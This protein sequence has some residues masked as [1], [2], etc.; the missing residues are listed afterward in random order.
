MLE[1]QATSTVRSLSETCI[2]LVQDKNGTDDKD[3]SIPNA[4]DFENVR[5]LEERIAVLNFM[6]PREEL[7]ASPEQRFL[8]QV[9]SRCSTGNL[10]NLINTPDSLYTG[11]LQ[12]NTP[13]NE[14]LTL[15]TSS[16]EEVRESSA[17]SIESFVPE[18]TVSTLKE[19]LSSTPETSPKQSLRNTLTTAISIAKQV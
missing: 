7:P 4:A 2:D 1:S 11:R 6:N 10:D 13:E 18:S 14:I 3:L 12:D 15:Q 9:I 19:L 5:E 17:N 16:M 8:Q